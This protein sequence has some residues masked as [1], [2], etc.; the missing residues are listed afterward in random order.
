M[1]TMNASDERLTISPQ[2]AMGRVSLTVADLTRSE[3][4]YRDALGMGVLDRAPG[5]L[6]LSANGRTVLLHLTERPGARPKPGRATGLY[7]FALLVPSRRDLG[8]WLRH[9]LEAGYPVPGSSDHLVSEAIYL[10]DPDGNGIEVYRDRPRLDWNWDH[11]NVRMAVDPL[12]LRALLTE[13]A[14]DTEPWT[15]IAPGTV[16][17]HVHLHVA[18]LAA[19]KAFYVDLLGFDI[20]TEALPGALFVSAGG[21]HHHMG[22]NI[23]AGQGASPAPAEAAGLR[24]RRIARASSSQTRPRTACGSSSRPNPAQTARPEQRADGCGRHGGRGRRA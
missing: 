18:D 22:L 21:Y 6:T 16:M 13:A 15:G 4:F 24:L 3:A 11:G 14:T 8:R 20:T 19:A 7:H 12:D 23:W 1:T 10:A 9:Y 17:G 2:T 5:T